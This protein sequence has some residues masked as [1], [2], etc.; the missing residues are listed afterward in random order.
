VTGVE[1]SLLYRGPLESCNYACAYCPFAKKKDSRADLAR[2]RAALERFV[3][4]VGARTGDRVSVLFT[5]WG[6]GLVR[7]WYRRALVTL[8]QMPHVE[9]AA[10]QTNLSTR[11]DF[12]EEAVAGKLGIWATFHPDWTTRARF[13]TQVERL[14]ALGARVSC[15]VVAMRDS[16]REI[17]LLR[18]ALPRDVYLWVNAAKSEARRSTGA[19]YT[20]ADRARLAAVDPLF[21]INAEDHPSAGRSCRAGASVVSVDGDGDVRRC[22]FVRD[23]IGNLYD[24]SFDAAL[25]ER[26]CPNATCG[27]HIGYVHLDALDLRAT[28]AG[29]VL[30]RIPAGWPATPKTRAPRPATRRALPIA[31]AVG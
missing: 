25:R 29:G 19:Y 26:P 7:R 13:V 9:R 18:E 2:D 23:V 20:D 14:V 4:W 27:C 16:V 21:E 28:F 17:E 15:G 31:R 12:A 11:L 1:L 22:H 24:G 30:E 8:T 10:I 6:E 3:A 5:P